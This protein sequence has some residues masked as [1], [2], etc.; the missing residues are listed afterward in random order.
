ML[1]PAKDYIVR[2]PA[3]KKTGGTVLVGGHNVVIV[4]GAITVPETIST[5][6]E[7]R[8]IYIKGATGTV[9]IEGVL[10]DHSGGGD[11]DGIAIAARRRLCRSRT[12]GSW[13]C[14]VAMKLSTA[15]SSSPG[16]G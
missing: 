9:H 11:F 5:D 10:I 8:G 3:T 15:T 16:A 14:A 4:G 13:A 6:T 2:L 12:P 7:R 1:D